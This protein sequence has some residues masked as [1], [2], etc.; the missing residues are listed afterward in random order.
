[1]GAGKKATGDSKPSDSPAVGNQ[2]ECWWKNMFGK[3]AVQSYL[4]S[5][6][7]FIANVTKKCGL[8]SA[9]AAHNQALL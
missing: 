4:S 2:T 7:V 6:T 3:S 5:V 1:M 8:L 9:T